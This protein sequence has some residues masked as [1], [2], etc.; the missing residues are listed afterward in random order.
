MA[1]IGR[2]GETQITNQ[3]IY[4]NNAKAIRPDMVRDVIKSLIE[5]NFNLVDDVLKDMNYSTGI[6]LEQQLTASVGGVLLHTKSSIINVRD[7][8]EGS[9]VSGDS[10]ATFKIDSN[11]GN[12]SEELKV[13]VTFPD[14]G[15]DYMP[16]ISFE[17]T[18]TP[19]H[20]NNAVFA[21]FGNATRTSISVYLQRIFDSPFGK[22]WLTLIKV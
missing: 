22:I 19:W 15:S 3:K 14:V 11:D 7:Q 12:H 2:S 10:R 8:A 18:G 9:N 5:S 4:D 20:L 1:A 21:T 13:D 16:V 6:T 17:A